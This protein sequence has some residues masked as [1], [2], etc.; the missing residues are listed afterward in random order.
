MLK[1]DTIADIFGKVVDDLE[2]KLENIEKNS[3]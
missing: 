3:W 1:D 2:K